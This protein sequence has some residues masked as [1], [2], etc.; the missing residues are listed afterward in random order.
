MP[1]QALL[2]GLVRSVVGV[3]GVLLLDAEGEVVVQAGER[4]DAQRL[5]GAYHGI[6]LAQ[7]RRSHARLACGSVEYVL[8]RFTGGDVIVRPLK[9][10]YYIVVALGPGANVG[11]GLHRSA[12]LQR[13]MNARL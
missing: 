1:Y 12:E 13:R 8:G 6:A 9:D 10:G 3:R 7:V 11:R 5:L 4:G 2:D